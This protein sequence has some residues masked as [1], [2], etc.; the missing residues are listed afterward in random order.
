MATGTQNAPTGIIRSAPPG[1][2]LTSTVAD[3]LNGASPNF[4][5][6]W[7]GW[8]NPSYAPVSGSKQWN[9]VLFRTVN[10]PLNYTQLIAI[11]SN[12]TTDTDT[13]M[14]IY[15]YSSSKWLKLTHTVL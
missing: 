9:F 14:Y 2:T 6:I 4:I 12:A 8:L 7:G 13:G 5:Y 10:S 15:N 11:C 3:V 1:I